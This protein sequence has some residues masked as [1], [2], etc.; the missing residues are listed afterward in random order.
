MNSQAQLLTLSQWRQIAFSAALLERMLPNYKMFTDNVEF[1]NPAILR[2]QLDLIWQWLDKNNRCKINYDAQL[3]K[4][5]EQIPDPESFEFFGV[6]PALDTCM[7]LM[8]LLQAMQ[9]K[10]TQGFSNVCRLSENSVSAYIELLLAHE[11]ESGN[12]VDGS[13]DAILAHP[14]M[15]WEQEVQQELLDVLQNAPENKQTCQ[16]IKALVLEEGLSNLGIEID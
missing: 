16:K 12:D 4:L 14:L 13:D 9:D 3:L 7:A 1:G 10:D 11:Q 5:E 6:F 2:N 15:M 8:S